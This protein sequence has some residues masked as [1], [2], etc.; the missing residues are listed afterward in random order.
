MDRT[1]PAA[2]ASH[3]ELP[4]A[5][6][7]GGDVGEAERARALALVSECPECES[8]LADFG[9]IA[10]ASAAL[11]VPP[12]P[13]DFSL[14][15]ADATRL[16]GKARGRWRVLGPGLR[17]SLGGSLA[18]LGIFGV[19]LTGTTSILGGTASTMSG[20]YALSPERAAA[21]LQSGA[22]V[23]ASAGDA[24]SNYGP[25]GVATAAPAAMGSA[26]PA[27]A[28]A[29]SVPKQSQESGGAVPVADSGSSAALV[30]P[31]SAGSH[32]LAAA[33][34]AAAQAVGSGGSGATKTTEAAGSGSSGMDARLLWVVGF[35]ALFIVGL[36]LAIL[37]VRRRSR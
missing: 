7:Y 35:A 21:P 8:L 32:D 11:P 4:I 29:S 34:P 10:A 19:I 23:M 3:D 17:R 2:H 24:A 26:A 6:L 25:P 20:D 30:P 31:A 37:P 5:R 28:A 12:R 9:A 15:E 18:A 16:R 13:R 36:G 14:T 1:A 27:T 22:L 33:S